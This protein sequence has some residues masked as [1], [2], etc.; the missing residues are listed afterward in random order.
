M[1]NFA[2]HRSHRFNRASDFRNRTHQPS[3][4][5][6]SD[7]FVQPHFLDFA[8]APKAARVDAAFP[9]EHFD[10]RGS[11]RRRKPI[12]REQFRQRENA[13]AIESGSRGRELIGMPGA[14][15]YQR[16]VEQ[17]GFVVDENSQPQIVVFGGGHV[18]VEA[19]G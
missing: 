6:V 4:R 7:P 16:F 1:W 18:L 19:A 8:T 14:V 15:R 10:D 11:P 13:E 3:A 2:K 9:G 5:L 12:V 17:A